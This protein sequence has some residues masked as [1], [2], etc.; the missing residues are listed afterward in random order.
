ME[1]LFSSIL[2]AI[3]WM[4]G[5]AMLGFGLGLG[6]L[7]GKITEAVGRNPDT[8]DDVVRSALIVV[9]TMVVLFVLLLG[10]VGVLL[11]FNPLV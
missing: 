7:G 3:G 1:T 2:S 10:A 4:I 6:I 5:L 8:K 9:L 11:F